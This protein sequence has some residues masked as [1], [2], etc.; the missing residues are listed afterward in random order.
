MV[1]GWQ[2]TGGLYVIKNAGPV[3]LLEE[4]G[5]RWTR[6]EARLGS[7]S[8]SQHHDV[9][10]AV[11]PCYLKGCSQH[12][13]LSATIL[14]GMVE[15]GWTLSHV[16]LLLKPS[17]CRWLNWLEVGL[18]DELKDLA[19]GW[20]QNVDVLTNEDAMIERPM[21]QMIPII[22]AVIIF[23]SNAYYFSLFVYKTDSEFWNWLTVSKTV[24]L[25]YD[26]W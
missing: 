6:L 19:T 10:V 24:T 3:A 4:R 15:G 7:H 17:V 18:Q 21:L 14:N 26:L 8:C 9:D 25:V 16:P 12:F 11:D 13:E 20:S 22:C 1:G 23:A 2:F 5:Q